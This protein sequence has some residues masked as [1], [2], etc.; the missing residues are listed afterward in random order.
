MRRLEAGHLYPQAAWPPPTNTHTHP[1]TH[2]PT[3]AHAQRQGVTYKAPF[4]LDLCFD[5]DGASGQR[6]V[7]KR[8]GALPVMVKSSA[9]YLRGLTRAELV[10][11]KE[12]STEFGG[13][14][15]CN[16]IER[17][18][19]MIVQQVGGCGV[20]LGARAGKH[21]WFW[22]RFWLRLRLRSRLRLW[23]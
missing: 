10:R 6:R 20:E 13:Y 15:I 17:I 3:H 1:P 5:S 21:R 7:Q 16:G 23:S 14:F 19:R 18:I 8:L 4:S 11:A 9:C 22:L 12:E 2:L